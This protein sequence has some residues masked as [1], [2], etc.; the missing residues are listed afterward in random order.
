MYVSSYGNRIRGKCTVKWS[1][2]ILR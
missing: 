2:Q 1:V